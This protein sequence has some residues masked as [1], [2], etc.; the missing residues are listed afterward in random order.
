MVEETGD[1]SRIRHEAFADHYSQA[2]QFYLSQTEYDQ[3]HIAFSL[4]FELSKVDHVHI[5][6]AIV[7]HLQ[8]VNADLAKRVAGGLAMDKIP[9]APPAAVPVKAMKPLPA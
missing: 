4:V 1:K 9:P 2:R 8:H 7:G 3:A 5:R 6:Q